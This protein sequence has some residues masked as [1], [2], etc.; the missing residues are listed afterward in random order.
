MER[1][2][3]TAEAKDAA[4]TEKLDERKRKALASALQLTRMVPSMSRAEKAKAPAR[5]AAYLGNA[6]VDTDVIDSEL[7]LFGSNETVDWKKTE[8]LINQLS[9]K[10]SSTTAPAA[11]GMVTVVDK[12]TGRSRRYRKDD[13][14][15][16]IFR[17]KSEVEVR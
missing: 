8:A 5:L 10:G 17:T 14:A 13:P 9:Q 11:D 6:G 7:N 12:A 15:V 3:I 16:A 4:S 2:R 1:A